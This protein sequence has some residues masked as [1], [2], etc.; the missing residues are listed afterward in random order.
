[1][2]VLQAARRF[3]VPAL[4]A[5]SGF[6][7]GLSGCAGPLPPQS[8]FILGTICTVNLYRKGSAALYRRVFDRFR[9][10][11]GWV[12]AHLAGSELDEINR[13]AGKEPVRVHGEV[14]ELIDRA[15]YYADI[16]DGAF[17]PTVGPLVALWGIGSESPHIPAREELDGLLP[18]VNRRDVEI[19]RQNGTVFL[20]RQG[21]RLDLGAIAKGYAADEA[22]RII[23]EAGVKRAIIDL[24]GNVFAYGEKEN[25]EPWRIAVQN[26]LEE[27]GAYIGIAEVRNKTVVTSGV[28]ERYVEAGG[29]RYHHILSPR[30]GYPAETGLLSVT[31]IADSSLDADGLSTG[32]FVLGYEAGRALIESRPGTEAIFV[33]DDLSVRCTPG[34]LEY[35]TLTNPVFT[36]E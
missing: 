16:S 6:A 18:L 10:L 27:R 13:M 12:S 17:D 30:T 5:L 26:P 35:F 25:G 2:K 11:E 23:R 14:L 1:M 32:A 4:L 3:L 33:L 29:R 15:L 8:E 28:Y 7:A 34:A 24:G 36:L 21:M 31:I 19:D 9:E 20:R 22:R